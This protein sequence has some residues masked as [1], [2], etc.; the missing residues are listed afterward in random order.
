MGP[1]DMAIL[2]MREVEGIEPVA[3]F[4]CRDRNLLGMQADMIGANALGIYNI[5]IITGDPPKLGDY[6]LRPPCMT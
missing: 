5:L 3:H 1:V 2:L 6:P 4:C